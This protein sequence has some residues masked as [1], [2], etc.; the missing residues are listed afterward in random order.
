MTD[1]L[2]LPV[3]DCSGCGACCTEIGTPPGFAVF[4]PPPGHEVPASYREWPDWGY[5]A[6]AP[7]AVRDELA[8]YYAAV[9]RGEVADRSGYPVACLWYDPV[10]RA[11]RHYEYRPE[12]CRDFRANSYSCRRWRAAAG[13]GPVPDPS[14]A[15]DD[16]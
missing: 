14:E 6:A 1:R 8:A 5:L 7:P 9:D 4:F 10:A 11:C 16:D 13:L 2:P 12:V 15:G 3:A